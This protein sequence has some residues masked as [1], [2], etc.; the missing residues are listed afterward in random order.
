MNFFKKRKNRVVTIVLGS[1][2]VTTSAIGIAAYS[3]TANRTYRAGDLGYDSSSPN[4]IPK[5]NLDSR[6]ANPSNSDSN[7]KEKPKEQPKPKENDQT[8][9]PP[10]QQEETKPATRPS[11]PSNPAQP[12]P[13]EQETEVEING[14]KVKAWVVPQKDRKVNQYDKDKGLTN[15]NPYQNHIVP[16]LKR[17]EVTP[18][19]ERKNL[20][21]A[22]KGLDNWQNQD[23]ASKMALPK[24]KDFDPE[25]FAKQNPHVWA[26]LLDKFK[27]LL[28]SPNV[29]KFLKEDA[30]VEYE[31]GKKFDSEYQ[32][33]GWLIANLD[34]SKFKKTSKTAKEYLEKGLIADP[35]N[36]YI[37]ENG[38]VDS[39]A[40]SPP[41]D[42]NTA[43]SR[44]ERDNRD[45]RVF[46]YEGWEGRN[47]GQIESGTYKGWTKTDKT[48]ELNNKHNLGIN[49]GDGIKISEL[50][51]DKEIPGKLNQGYVVEIDASNPNG[52]QKAKKLIEDLKAKNIQITGYRITN[53]GKNDSNQQFKE[54]LR[55]LPDELP[56]LELF[57]AASAANTSSLIELENKKIKE[58]SLYTLGNSLLDKWSLN[59]WALKNVEWVNNID[60]NVSWD[61]RPGSKVA[62]RITFDTLAFE[63]SDYKKGAADPYERINDGLRM[64]YWVRNNEPIFQG[65]M[66]PGLK[67][68]HKEGENSYATGLDLSRVPSMKSLRGL[69]FYDK[70][71]SEN[72]PRKLKRLT[73]FNDKNVFEMDIEE[74][75]QAGFDNMA[76]TEMGPPPTKIMFSN[77]SDTRNLRIKGTQ[78]LSSTGLQNLRILM[79]ICDNLKG[80]K[81]KVDKNATDLIN[82]LKSNGY[83]VETGEDYDFT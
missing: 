8:S 69:V 67:P 22:K 41:K 30:R 44:M 50:K 33:Y 47:P 60:Y 51:R 71:K 31:K 36:A 73:L 42:Y 61:Y 25:A 10:K 81:I 34:F 4:L 3:S 46:G 54:I 70:F 19:L 7:L 27:R 32:R 16:D 66:G 52:Y 11:Q 24:T 62:T 9:K 23:F 77:G 63:E 56:Q 29:S 15:R 26:K 68:D 20:E 55:A 21:N 43:T 37:N 1:A 65:G 13:G 35:D 45:R 64:A 58:L 80:T 72:K 6:G 83:G 82:Q 40:Y 79:A 17:I 49:N 28:D 12:Q 59:P 78:T 74:L 39:Y 18:E 2:I 76:W 5:D 57:F 75:N 14:E 48:N 38:E 53:M